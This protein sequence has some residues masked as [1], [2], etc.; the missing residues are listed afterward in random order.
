MAIVDTSIFC[1]FLNI[2]NMNSSR[3]EVLNEFEKLVR[4]DTSFLLPIT[5][6]YETGNHIAQLSDGGNCR[7]FAQAFVTE[8][9]KAINGDAPWQIMRV[10]KVEEIGIWLNEFPDSAMRKVSMGDLSIIKEWEEAKKKDSLSPGFYLVFRPRL[11]R[12]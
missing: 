6:V 4:N 8:V 9:H 1:E 10:P 7:R 11:E 5:A 2:P 3:E 12:I